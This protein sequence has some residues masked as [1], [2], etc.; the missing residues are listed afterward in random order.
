MNNT[1]NDEPI[2]FKLNVCGWATTSTTEKKG[3]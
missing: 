3:L 1:K 2:E